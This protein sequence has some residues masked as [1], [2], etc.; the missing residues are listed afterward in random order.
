MK[1]DHVKDA[2][3][4]LSDLNIFY[5]VI[6][7]MDGGLIHAPSHASAA[8][9]IKICKEEGRRCLGRFDRARAASSGER[10]K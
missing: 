8:R 2:A 3:V 10:R 7:L 4:A 9:I 1:P 6:A 5:A